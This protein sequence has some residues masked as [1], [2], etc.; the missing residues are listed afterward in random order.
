VW[1]SC[2]LGVAPASEMWGQHPIRKPSD[3]AATQT[4]ACTICG[5][6]VTAL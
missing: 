6:L 3:W 2:W 5:M 4:G 1:L